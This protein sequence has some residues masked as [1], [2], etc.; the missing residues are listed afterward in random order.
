MSSTTPSTPAPGTF[1]GARNP[2]IA[3]F[4]IVLSQ[5]MI[6]LDATVVNIALPSIR[7]DLD[8][9]PT[10]IAWVSS[11]YT[12]AFAG[13]LLMGGRLGDRLGRR[14]MFVLGLVL[15]AVTSLLAGLAPTSE[16]LLV[17]RLAQGVAAALAAPNSLALV[18]N[19]FEE[20]PARNKALGAVA[21]S[22]AASLA[23]GLILGGLLT[24][25]LSWRWVMFIITPMAV[26]VLVLAPIY[27][28]EAERH[29]GPY[30]VAGM[31]VAAA[32]MVSL[33]Y[34]LLQAAEDGWSDGVVWGCL[35]AALVLFLVF[36]VV[37]RSAKDPLVPMDLFTSRNRGGGY[38]A[39]L[40]LVAPM[41]AMNFF[42]SQ[43]I[44]EGFDFS[45]MKAGFAFLPLAASIMTAGSQAAGLMSRLGAKPVALAGI[46]LIFVGVLW[47]SLISDDAGYA[48]GVLG[49]IM[50][51]GAGSGL[52]FT[53]L[54]SYILSDVSG[55]NAGSAS[56]V[57]EL[58]QWV[59]FT[60][61]VSALTS[62]YGNA[63]REALEAVP[64]D[65]DHALVEGIGAAFTGGLAFIVMS[66][67]VTVFVIRKMA[68]PPAG[69]M[70]TPET[71]DVDRAE[72]PKT[73]EV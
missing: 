38:L 60:L 24:D 33:V 29:S 3:M 61:G 31:I 47:I 20:G 27:V 44:Q 18:T 41:A 50:F 9:S 39:L 68:A 43:L 15:F 13:L 71:V 58:F 54:T 36:V 56:S 30:D 53:A 40:G 69:T 11:A 59:G 23:L 8:F 65:T 62:I 5:F 12:L 55:K 21:G 63:R 48:S 45:P 1:Q 57:L 35:A 72:T 66:L 28:V 64:G 32:A 67:L 26:L 16:W 51:F 7:A 17:W 19:N 46:G 37:E 49:P 2:G 73:S 52:A 14:N 42:V 6:G 25:Q 10:G 22:Y 4:V 70:Q 34:G